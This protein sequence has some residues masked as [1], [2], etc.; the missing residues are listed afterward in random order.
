VGNCKHNWEEF[1]EPFFGVTVKCVDCDLE[2]E[3]EDTDEGV[4]LECGFV[5]PVSDDREDRAYEAWR[6]AV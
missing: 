1:R 3:H 2:C 4:C 5:V 6:E